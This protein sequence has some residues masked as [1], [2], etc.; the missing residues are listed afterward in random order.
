MFAK[1]KNLFVFFIFFIIM[2]CSIFTVSVEGNE[3]KNPYGEKKWK[4]NDAS[5]TIIYD[6]E[7]ELIDMHPDEADRDLAPGETRDRSVFHGNLGMEVRNESSGQAELTVN[8]SDIENQYG[9]ESE[10]IDN[11]QFRLIVD[12]SD[13]IAYHKKTEEK[14]GFNPFYFF[15]YNDIDILEGEREKNITIDD[16]YK[17]GY[18]E[19]YSIL[20]RPKTNPTAD[21]KM[22]SIK[23]PILEVSSSDEIKYTSISIYEKGQ[24]TERAK[25]RIAAT[26]KSY[27]P[28]S[29]DCFLPADI[30]FNETT[31]ERYVNLEAK[32]GYHQEEVEE[33]L[34]SLELKKLK[35]NQSVTKMLF[36]FL[37]TVVSLGAILAYLAYRKNR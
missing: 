19:S 11:T 36:V 10:M 22:Y 16:K 5:L 2:F 17:F 7:G 6:D 4:L 31:N 3:V 20:T 28:T 14:I 26:G 9:K 37:G 35:R 34:N 23:E 21:E 8:F 24:D 32:I 12:K 25:S 29:I 13:N 15:A 1:P 18:R 30:F 27:Y 33:Y